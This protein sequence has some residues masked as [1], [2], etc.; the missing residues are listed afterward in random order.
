MW[1]ISTDVMGNGSLYN[2]L[3]ESSE[4]DK[5]GSKSVTG[6]SFISYV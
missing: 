4:G 2:A 5:H 3:T 1:D 6:N